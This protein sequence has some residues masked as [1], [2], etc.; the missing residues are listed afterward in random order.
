MEILKKHFSDFL[1]LVIAAAIFVSG[2]V[3]QP[4]DGNGNL[5]WINPNC[6]TSTDSRYPH[7][8]GCDD[9]FDRETDW[10]EVLSNIDVYEF[11][12][13]VVRHNENG[14]INKAVLL[15]EKYDV[16]ISVVV[17]GT[18]EYAGCDDQEGEQSAAIELAKIQPIYDAGG[19]VTYI[20]LDGPIS[21][22]IATGR[23]NNCGFTLNQSIQE[24]VDYMKTF[25]ETRPEV[26]IGIIVNF[27]NWDYGDYPYTNLA[28]DES[29]G[30]Y[31]EV[32]EE[33][34]AAVEAAGEEIYFVRVD[35]PYREVTYINGVDWMQRIMLLRDQVT[36]HNIRFG[37][38]FNSAQ[39]E[40]ISDQAYYE[41]ALTYIT[42]YQ[43]RSETLP[44]DI[45]LQSWYTRPSRIL[46]E[47]EPYTFMYHVKSFIDYLK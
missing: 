18:L 33:T 27:P 26:K 41:N 8:T 16:A 44:H 15:L 12:G 7:I 30:D 6:F 47:N 43:N 35:R 1:V 42:M 31:E 11:K 46:P 13:A 38:I 40:K 45:V 14:I 20:A 22:T 25:H 28:H 23:P 5:I 36:S 32:L 34:I 4:S 29:W 24:L 17:G 10:E 19:S 21:R 37:V 2:C 39:A 3:K 9:L